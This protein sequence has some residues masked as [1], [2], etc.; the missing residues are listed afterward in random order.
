M[1][2]F[3]CAIL[4]S[5]IVFLFSIVG[6]SGG[7]RAIS[8]VQ[9]ETKSHTFE[10]GAKGVIRATEEIP[11]T[12]PSDVN[13]SFE[14]LWLIPEYSQVSRGQVIARFDDAAV[15]TEIE[16]R[17]L[18]LEEQELSILN[19]ERGNDN[20][21]TQILH[22]AM[23][24]DGDM[25]IAERYEGLDESVF[26]RNEIIDALD[27]IDT[28]NVRKQFYAWQ[29]QSHE[30]RVQAETQQLQA[31]LDITQQSL[32]RNS[33]ALNIMELKSPEDGTFVYAQ[34]RWGGGKVAPGQP[35]WSGRRVGSLP[36]R[37]AVDAEIHVLE[38]DAVGIEEGQKVLF[39]I[40]SH[41]DK[42][43]TGVVTDVPRMARSLERQDPTKYRIIKAEFDDVDPDIMRVGS[44]FAA[45]VITGELSD[46]ILVPQQAVFFDEDRP[47]VYVLQENSQPE[48]RYVELGRKSPTLI[49]ITGG[50]ESGETISLVAP[51]QVSA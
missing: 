3:K 33:Q 16:R 9:V 13:M 36:I 45:T 43:F 5:T 25:E 49:E 29:A 23:Q 11:I 34:Q 7:G 50:L 12:V 6:C 44:S 38:V 31:N 22:S 37:G 28:L 48:L 10:V 20:S 1:A 15:L 41:V 19:F 51:T 17:Q 24:V 40:D 47:L 4:V 27:N 46:V 39:R 2:K 14:I 30:R 32:D 42:V 35:V 21:R 18:E 26:S 8:T